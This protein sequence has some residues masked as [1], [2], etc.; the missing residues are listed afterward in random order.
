V[1]EPKR[2]TGAGP[3]TRGEARKESLQEHR[4]DCVR[5]RAQKVPEPRSVISEDV[6]LLQDSGI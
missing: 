4:V 2:A 6:P 1:Q 3:G 5:S